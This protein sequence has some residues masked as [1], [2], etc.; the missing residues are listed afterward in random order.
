M[1]SRYRDNLPQ[2]K[3]ASNVP[4]TNNTIYMLSLNKDLRQA[5]ATLLVIIG[6]ISCRYLNNKLLTRRSRRE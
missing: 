5:S 6:F 3:H 4:V 1:T 2:T